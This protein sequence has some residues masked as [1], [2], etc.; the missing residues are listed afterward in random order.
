MKV[1]VLLDGAYSDKSVQAVFSTR[2]KAEAFVKRFEGYDCGDIVEREVDD[3][4]DA[5]WPPGRAWCVVVHVQPALPSFS[6]PNGH[7]NLQGVVAHPDACTREWSRLQWGTECDKRPFRTLFWG[8]SEQA[9]A[10][11]EAKLVEERSR[12]PPGALP[13]AYEPR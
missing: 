9:K 1:F 8:T 12:L 10:F 13:G 5:A 6:S 2:E 4:D 3:Y 7:V 11:G